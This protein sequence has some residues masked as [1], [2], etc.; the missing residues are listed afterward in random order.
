MEKVMGVK[1]VGCDEYRMEVQRTGWE[2]ERQRK[3]EGERHRLKEK[4]DF[5]LNFTIKIHACRATQILPSA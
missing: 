1:A 3:R 2:G 5:L 4:I